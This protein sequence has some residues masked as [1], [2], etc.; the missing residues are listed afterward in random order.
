MLFSI[1]SLLGNRLVTEIQDCTYCCI[2]LLNFIC[3]TLFVSIELLFKV[4]YLPVECV[5]INEL[6]ISVIRKQLV[7]NLNLKVMRNIA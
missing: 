4:V 5:H 2:L 6:I 3:M 7:V 1:S